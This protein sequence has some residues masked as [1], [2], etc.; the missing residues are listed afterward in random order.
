MSQDSRPPVSRLG[1]RRATEQSQGAT[2]EPAAEQGPLGVR[3]A[4][5]AALA[6]FG[7][8]NWA[9]LVVDPPLVRAGVSVLV[10]TAGGAVLA[11]IGRSRLDALPAW[12]LGALTAL[13]ATVAALVVMGL[14]PGLLW[15]GNWNELS[16]NVDF[17]LNGIADQV[18]YPYAGDNIWSRRAILLG[19]PLIL[20]L[21]VA[22]S[23]WPRRRWR[24]Q[25]ILGVKRTAAMP[26]QTLGLL[27]LAIL[28]V[29]YA[30][31]AT[32]N[33][34]G[35]PLIGGLAL[36]VLVAGWLWL[37]GLR[38]REAGVATALVALAAVVAVPLATQLDNAEGFIDYRN[39]AWSS[40]G[41]TTFDWEHSY[42]PIDWPRNDR[43]V[44]RVESERPLY[45]KLS[46]LDRFDGRRWLIDPVSRKPFELPSEVE[47]KT[48]FPLLQPP[49]AEWV[50]RARFEVGQLRSDR[51]VGAGAIRTIKGLGKNAPRRSNGGTWTVAKDLEPG[52]AYE[53]QVYAPNPDPSELRESKERYPKLLENSTNIGLIGAPALPGDPRC[54]SALGCVELPTGAESGEAG[55]LRALDE[56]VVPIRGRKPPPRR[57][58]R[59][60]ERIQNSP[61]ARMLD[62]ATDLTTDAPTTY[63]AVNAVE[64]HLL[65]EYSYS[66]V[67]PDRTFPLS[68]F[69]FEDRIGYCQQFSGAMALMLRMVGIP[70][71]VVSG[72]AP[73]VADPEDGSYTVRN[74]DAHSWVEGFFNGIGWVTFDPT[75]AAAPAESQTSDDGAGGVGPGRQ[76]SGG[77]GDPGAEGRIGAEGATAA[78]A[79]SAGSGSSTLLL[80]PAALALLLLAGAALAG[81]RTMSVRRLS[82]DATATAQLHEL[83]SALPRLGLKLPPG[84]T[85]LGLE[86]GL[87]PLAGDAST[88]YL[89]K[90]RARRYGAAAQAPPTRGE[91]RAV[92]RGLGSNRGMQAR[93]AAFLAMPPWGPRR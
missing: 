66:E 44:L 28:V 36:F 79:A 53:V 29:L 16:A 6:A 3:L 76:A 58:A 35:A 81:A 39:W 22:A 32:E 11:R 1:G 19:A 61:Y 85:L 41:G 17:G 40:Q 86:R 90:L 78:D 89:S 10:V 75:P 43:R 55:G 34:S 67:P 54:T 80:V 52:D 93:L 8:M 9:G 37:P 71:R 56:V 15:I 2:T 4:I 51:V 7:A 21:A 33:P 64:T 49:P 62:L 82:A 77:F 83:E 20:G 47:K 68:D 70:A 92:R 50:T 69:L 5:F 73:G 12:T 38:H 46:T 23:F 13:I 24:P 87:H 88:R 45:W 63:D 18:D 59:V 30:V 72:F 74:L 57:A 27:G 91:R 26:R 84:A 14:P 31:P 42:G 60:T 65:T 25:G 48:G